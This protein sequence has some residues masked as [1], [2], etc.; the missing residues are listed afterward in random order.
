MYNDDNEFL[1]DE[2]W[3]TYGLSP[4][5][6]GFARLPIQNNQDLAVR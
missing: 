3:L 2:F 4:L 6:I 1:G 5:E